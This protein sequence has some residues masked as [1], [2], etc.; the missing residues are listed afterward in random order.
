[1]SKAFF[2][3]M[4]RFCGT[5]AGFVLVAVAVSYGQQAIAYT[6]YTHDLTNVNPAYSLIHRVGALNTLLR[7]QWL[8]MDDAPAMVM[9]NGYAPLR[10]FGGSVGINILHDRIGPE[11]ATDI[12]LF[13]AKSVRLTER[14]YL[15]TSLGLGFKRYEL[16]AAQYAPQDQVF[17]ID[18]RETTGN[19]SIG[20]ILYHPNRY[21]ISVSAPRLSLGN[22]GN[23][24][25]GTESYFR[26]NYYIAAAYLADLGGG[27][28]LKP[29]VL[30]AIVPQQPIV[31]DA[32]TTVYFRSRFGLGV[33]YRTTDHLGFMGYFFVNRF[34][35]GYTYQVGLQRQL[36]S[37]RFGGTSHE[38]GLGYRFGG[39]A[40]VSL[41]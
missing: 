39:L 5:A 30:A 27:I 32:V 3:R 23:A 25:D 24:Q 34:R 26:D 29:A 13:A 31:M 6:Q 40:D 28:K 9:I 17:H 11:R 10:R 18:E 41:L 1:M 38:V 16:N 36:V 12:G 8:G 7:R 19:L 37:D 35:M 15:G 2:S 4:T 22:A 14:M 33:N 20:L 21:Y